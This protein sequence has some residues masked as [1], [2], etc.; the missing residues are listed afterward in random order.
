MRFDS[1]PTVLREPLVRALLFILLGIAAI[2]LT[3]MLWTIVI[4]FGDLILLFSFAWIIS[5]LL[6]PIVSALGRVRWLPRSAAILL[7]YGALLL[8]LASGVTLLVPLLISQ[9]EMAAER[10]PDLDRSI[11]GWTAGLSAT[12]EARGVTLGDYTGELVRP[13]ESVG[14]WFVANAVSLATATA[15]I[16]TQVVLALV[17]SLYFMFDGE[18]LGKQFVGAIPVRYRDEVRFF[19]GSINRAFG[20]FLRGQIIQAL[21]Y[22]LGIAAIMLG[23]GL[24]FAALTSFLA[25]LSIFVPF[26]GPIL[27][28]AVPILIALLTDAGKTWLVA[29]LSVG[30]NLVVVNVVAPKVM[31]REIGL[32]PVFVLAAVIIGARVGGPWGAL[33]GIPVAAVI[34]TMVSFYQLTLTERERHVEEITHAEAPDIGPGGEQPVPAV[35][36]S[37]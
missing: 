2:T 31:S 10:L 34:S 9:S 19:T 4:Q 36:Q 17:L 26:L 24:P 13:L 29:I 5:F 33:F 16:L 30:L 35:G 14:S 15:S 20:A 28:T 27:A 32:S 6:E 12:L 23:T 21:V 25:G 37:P 7:V 1:T 22:G 8:T 11:R 3:Q 18:R